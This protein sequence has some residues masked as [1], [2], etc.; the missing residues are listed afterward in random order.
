LTARIKAY[1]QEKQAKLEQR[2]I[3]ME[4]QELQECMFAPRVR[5]TKQAP[6]V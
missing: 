3:E 5:K 1:E 6:Q 2:R 4:R